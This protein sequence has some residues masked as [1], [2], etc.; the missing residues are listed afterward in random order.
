MGGAAERHRSTRSAILAVAPDTASQHSLV[1]QDC[2]SLFAEKLA[3]YGPAWRMFRLISVIDQIY[4]K[5]RRIRR[6]EELD[7]ASL[8]ED[9]AS[10]EYVGIINY[11][12]VGIWHIEEGELHPPERLEEVR[13]EA[14]WTDP[15]IARERHLEV[16]GRALQLLSRKNHDYG[17]AWRGMAIASLT[18]EL[19]SRCVRMKSMLEG[20][21]GQESL[22]SQLYDSINYAAF[23]LI[24]LAEEQREEQRKEPRPSS[25]TLGT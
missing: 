25:P 10:E 19:L 16:M 17:E 22:E 15:Q 20:D 14:R 6:L 8:V 18:D 11:A 12:V 9:S 23:A 7:G 24:R 4:I 3:E 1:A 21:R 2:A 5:A 13:F